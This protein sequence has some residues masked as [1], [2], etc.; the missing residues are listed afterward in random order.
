VQAEIALARALQRCEGVSGVLL[1]PAKAAERRSRDLG[2]HER[3]SSST[4]RVPRPQPLLYTSLVNGLVTVHGPQRAQVRSQGASREGTLRP[5]MCASQAAVMKSW[6]ERHQDLGPSHFD[7]VNR[8]PANSLVRRLKLWASK[9]TSG[10]SPPDVPRFLLVG[11]DRRVPSSERCHERASRL[12]QPSTFTTSAIT[13]T[14]SASFTTSGA[15]SAFTGS[16]ATRPP[17]AR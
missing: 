9:S 11:T 2:R 4:L 10:P 8:D 1:R 15:N 12:A 13:R 5:S 16:S 6:T 14:S 17:N 7:S 3:R